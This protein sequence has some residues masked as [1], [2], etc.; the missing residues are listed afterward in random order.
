MS[1]SFTILEPLVEVG[2]FSGVLMPK[3]QSIFGETGNETTW[4]VETE[5]CCWFKIL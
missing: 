5:V 1:I 2:G 4:F 3:S